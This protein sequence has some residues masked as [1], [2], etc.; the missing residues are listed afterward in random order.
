MKRTKDSVSAIALLAALLAWYE[1]QKAEE[2]VERN[3]AAHYDLTQY[4]PAPRA[5]DASKK[6]RTW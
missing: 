2:S 3:Q 6:P 4:R 5:W 1:R